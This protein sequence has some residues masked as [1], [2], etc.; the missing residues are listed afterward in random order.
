[1]RDAVPPPRRPPLAA[2][3]PEILGAED[4]EAIAPAFMDAAAHAY[5]AGG[6]GHELTLQ[7]NRAAFAACGIRP[8]LLRP[9]G[10]GHTRLRL[11]GAEYA[12][13]VFLAPL[14]YQKLAHPAGEI[15]TA[16]GAAA[17]DSCLVLSTLASASLEEVA[18]AAGPQRWFQLYFQND[19]AATRDLL[20]RAEAAGYR[21]LVV[22]LDTTIRTPGRRAQRAGFALPP[23]VRAVNLEP[24]PEPPLPLVGPGESRIFQGI[25]RQAPTLD[26]LRWLLAESRLPVLVKGVLRADDA[27]LLQAL[28]VAGQIVSN[29]GGRALDGA[30]ASLAVLP[31]IRAALGAGYPLLVD[32]GI[33]CGSDVFKALAAGADAVLVGRPQV[34]ALA[35]AGA[36]GVA[37]LLQ[38]LRD[39][40][41]LCMAQAGCATLADLTPAMID[42]SPKGQRC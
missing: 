2:I 24:Y 36:L 37:H 31:E 33:R 17:T 22:T 19:P 23:A 38:L 6:S 12:H 41:E 28:G 25:M 15:D 30:P 16:R 14:A 18:R 1:M 21:A 34:Y 20:R 4:Y 26:D 11:F 39:E 27:R 35:V 29:H 8:R 3:P 13:P 40:L 10:D 7:A 9:L 42:F 32:G 5:V